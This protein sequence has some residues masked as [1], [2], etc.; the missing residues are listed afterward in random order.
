MKKI[1]SIMLLVGMLL[2]TSGG[3][4]HAEEAECPVSPDGHC[5]DVVQRL[6]R[7]IWEEC[8]YCGHINWFRS[9]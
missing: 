1:L 7:S 8:T 2:S 3:V 6:G 9:I 4:A 5:N